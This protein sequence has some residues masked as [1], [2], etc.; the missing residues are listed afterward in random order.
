MTTVTGVIKTTRGVVDTV[1]AQRAATAVRLAWTHRRDRP[2][3]AMIA[4]PLAMN[5]SGL[6]SQWWLWIPLL[7]GAAACT[8]A[9]RWSWVLTFQ[10]G[11]MGTEWA[12]LGATSLGHWPAQRFV[13]GATWT[14][15]ALYL[16]GAA[17]LNRRFWELRRRR[18]SR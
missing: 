9:W 1:A 16:A 7:L 3:L 13:I 11:A 8:P 14:C 10:L 5:A 17:N 18:G 15:V 4:V 6:V 2:L 12:Y